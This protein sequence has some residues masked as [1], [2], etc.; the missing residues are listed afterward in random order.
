MQNSKISII[1]PVYNSEE[2]IRK[3]IASI[4]AQSE[5]AF[6]LILVDDGSKDNSGSICDEYAAL[7]QRIHV[8]HQDNAGVSAARN[9][10]I[11]ISCG[12]YLGFVDADDWIEPKMYAR[13]LEEAETTVSDI[14]MCDAV[15]V[16]SEG[17]TQA[18]TITRL[19]GN[20]FLIKSDFTPSLLLE[21]AGS[22]CRC[23]Y[24]K[25][26][27]DDRKMN[28]DWLHFPLGVK[29]S[30]DRIFNLYAFGK[31]ERIAYIKEPFYYRYVNKKS[32]VHR[33]H[34]DYFEAYKV[35]AQEIEKAVRLV[36]GDEKELQRAYL[37]QFITGAEM[38]I[39]N[40]Y[41]KTSTM[42][43]G[44]CLQALRKL[45]N[46]ESLREAI[47]RYGPDRKSGWIY[48]RNYFALIL[49]AHLAN[50]LHGR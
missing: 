31:A 4:L 19:S 43:H 10:G 45:C 39:C 47:R 21:M 42:S 8:V 22:A 28:P 1:V 26:L 30:E 7:D 24:S 16:Y 40:Y 33:F 23:I 48:H 6:E 38:A 50:F 29:F 20:A 41:Y 25:R 17:R 34:A 36:W 18:D 46:D 9:A 13:L 14:I 3:T 49:Y 11:A 27:F 2:T 37:G 5:N 15:T 12:D 32:T 35:A 44:E